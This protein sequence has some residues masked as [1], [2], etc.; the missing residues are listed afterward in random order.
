MDEKELDKRIAEANEEFVSGE[1]EVVI[2][3]PEDLYQAQRNIARDYGKKRFPRGASAIVKATVRDVVAGAGTRSL[4]R[5]YKRARDDSE[6][7]KEAGE[8]RRAELVKQTYM[9]ESFL[10]AV[11]I[12]VNFTSPDEVLNS[13]EALRTL[14]KYALGVGSMSGYTAAYIREAYRDMLG[15]AESASSPFVTE[16]VR[17]LNGLLDTDQMQ[18]AYAVA[19]KLKR[20]IDKG[21]LIA[22]EADYDLISK[23]AS[24]A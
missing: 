6:A 22:S 18:S 12:V 15:N 1:E 14:D 19:K 13:K 4:A 23:V 9:T 3:S 11:E 5:A 21:D 2:S 20:E 16:E 10:P 7:L 24:Y 17:R 8:E